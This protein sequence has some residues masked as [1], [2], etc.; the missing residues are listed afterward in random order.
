[1]IAARS[2][3]PDELDRAGEIGAEAFEMDVEDWKR[4]FHRHY[5]RF[6]AD[7]ILVVEHENELVS[8]MMITPEGLQMGDATVP[9]GAV[10]GVAT[11]VKARRLGCAAAMMRETVRR[12]AEWG[13]VGSAMWPFSYA[14]Y[15][16]FGWELGGEVR[17]VTWPRDIAWR[18]ELDGDVSPLTADDAGAIASVWEACAPQNRCSTVRRVDVWSHILRPDGHGGGNPGVPAWSAGAAAIRLAICCTTSPK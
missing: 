2:I 1:M 9:G 15:R 17:F 10:G 11:I 4:G 7:R 14:Y 5:D 8:A 16:K 6:G 13:T 3:K 12:M 18:V